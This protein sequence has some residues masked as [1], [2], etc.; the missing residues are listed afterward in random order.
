MKIIVPTR[1]PQASVPGYAPAVSDAQFDPPDVQSET[2]DV[3]D[4][5]SDA[6][7]ETPNDLGPAPD[8]EGDAAGALLKARVKDRLFL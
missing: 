6:T 2:P 4:A 3:I 7:D 5:P 1:V 8:V